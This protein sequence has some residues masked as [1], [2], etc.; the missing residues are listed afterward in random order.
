M[1]YTKYKASV[2]FKEVIPVEIV[3]ETDANVFLPNGHRAQKQGSDYK[4]CDTYEEAVQFVLAAFQKNL[5][6]AKQTVVYWEVQ[7]EKFTHK[8]KVQ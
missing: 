3:R 4:Y 8:H 7:L 2:L 5:N 6:D 1:R